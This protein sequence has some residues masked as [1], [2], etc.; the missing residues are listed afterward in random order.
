MAGR[1]YAL[2]IPQAL[3]PI[4]HHCAPC[5]L[6]I[7]L[8]SYCAVPPAAA[9]LVSTLLIPAL[10]ASIS[11]PGV[12]LDRHRSRLLPPLLAALQYPGHAQL[13]GARLHTAAPAPGSRRFP[14]PTPNQPLP[15]APAAAVPPGARLHTAA[16]APGSRRPSA[17]RPPRINRC[18]SLLRPWYRLVLG[19][20][21]P[22]QPQAPA[23]SRRLPAPRPPQNTLPTACVVPSPPL[24]ATFGI[25]GASCR[26]P[27]PAL[28]APGSS[29]PPPPSS[30]PPTPKHLTYSLRGTTPTAACHFCHLRRLSS[31]PGSRCSRPRLPPLPPALQHPAH[32]E[33]LYMG[34]VWHHVHRCPLFLRPQVTIIVP[35]VPLKTGSLTHTTDAG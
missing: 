8:R 17:P 10:C 14:P 13:P 33:A 2:L 22:F 12:P 26:H 4:W 20:V 27:A 19:C 21:P 6:L 31:A 7:P 25:R 32:P 9:S 34:F 1:C 15:V 5:S 3:S 28:P 11:W 18:P 16:P 30:S 35:V 29:R 23:A 24:H